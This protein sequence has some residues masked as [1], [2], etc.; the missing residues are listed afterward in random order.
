MTETKDEPK[1]GEAV[2]DLFSRHEEHALVVRRTATPISLQKS[3]RQARRAYAAWGAAMGL[4]GAEGLSV[5]VSPAVGLSLHAA[6]LLAFLIRAYFSAGPKRHLQLAL[7]VVPLTR[8][9]PMTLP[10]FDMDASLRLFASYGLLLFSVLTASALL[11]YRLLGALRLRQ[12]PYLVLGLG[13]GAA[14]GGALFFV[15]RPAAES[16]GASGVTLAAS[17]LVFAG[18][19]EELLFRG[20]LLFAAARVLGVGQGLVFSAV[21][22]AGFHL[23]WP[24]LVVGSLLVVGLLLGWLVIKSRSLLGA[25]LAHGALNVTLF[26]I[27]P[28]LAAS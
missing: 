23:G 12:L 2:Q 28:S 5:W 25:M 14:L 21:L 9:L 18:F 3:G 6:L 16:F 1:R 11:G 7:A 27:L 24:W 8:L 4:L 20:L 26:I 13:L 17:S 22:Y 10:A 19:T 15:L